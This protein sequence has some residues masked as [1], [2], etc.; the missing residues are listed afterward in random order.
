MFHPAAGCDAATFQPCSD[1]ALANLKVY[2]ESFRYGVY[3]INNGIPAN[4]AIAVGRYFE[5]VYFCGNPWYLTTLA[6]AEQLYRAVHTWDALHA[7]IEVTS[8][9]LPFFKQFLPSLKGPT[10]IAAGSNDYAKVI[11]SIKTYAD[12][13]VAI[14]AKYTP[15]DGGLSEQ[16][17]KLTGAPLSA[18]DLTW[19]YASALTAFDARAN[20]PVESWG[21]RGLKVP[22][23]CGTNPA[24]TSTLTFEVTAETIPGGKSSYIRLTSS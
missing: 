9:S 17:T 10:T 2:V 15:T 22:T 18:A 7:G 3:Y 5:D 4:E 8:I 6:V 23:V 1:K 20:A 24:P 13:F 21:A 19:S 11:N 12:G 16:F 14:V